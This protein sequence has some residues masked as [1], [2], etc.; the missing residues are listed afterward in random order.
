MRYFFLSY[1]CIIVLCP[2]IVFNILF[3]MLTF[4]LADSCQ[5]E[6]PWGAATGDL[7]QDPPQGELS[8]EPVQR[9]QDQMG[10]SKL[11]LVVHILAKARNF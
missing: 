11:S 7:D 3:Q 10:I 2:Q 8:Q 5:G 4:D 6:G 1:A 9:T